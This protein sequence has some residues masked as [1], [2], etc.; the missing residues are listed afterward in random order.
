MYDYAKLAQQRAQEIQR[1][2]DQEN[3]EQAIERL[4]AEG[5]ISTNFDPNSL[6]TPITAEGQKRPV[7]RPGV[8][9]QETMLR[10]LLPQPT[11]QNNVNQIFRGPPKPPLAAGPNQIQQLEPIEVT[12]QQ[13]IPVPQTRG[14]FLARGGGFSPTPDQQQAIDRGYFE[15]Q[16]KADAYANQQRQGR[17]KGLGNMMMVLSDALGGRPIEPGVQQRQQY[18]QQQQQIDKKKAQYEAIL[19]DPNT[20]P[21]TKRLLKSL[22]WQNM[23]QFLLK[24]YELDNRALVDN[25]TANQKN[26]D[27]YTKIMAEGNE[28]QKEFATMIFIPGTRQLKTK[29]DFIL[30][31]AEKV[32]GREFITQEEIKN[33]TVAA[34]NLYDYI[35]GLKVSNNDIEGYKVERVE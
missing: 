30:S 9:R 4:K 1:K 20:A 14:G 32:S 26:Y 13:R 25:R 8:S 34:G 2:R 27:A 15:G 24:K 31:I 7:E 6:I 21:A 28:Q 29:D 5:A 17:N 23:D 11:P 19:N 22:G 3:F 35:S 10:G 16:G 12:A 18:Q 33:A